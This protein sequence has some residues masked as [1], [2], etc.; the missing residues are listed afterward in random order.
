MGSIGLCAENF[1]PQVL[2]IFESI[3]KDNANTKY[4]CHDYL[5]LSYVLSGKGI[6]KVNDKT[7]KVKPGNLLPFNPNTYHRQ[8]AAKGE[9]FR[10]LHIGIKNFHF[11]G[12]PMDY[13]I[14]ANFFNVMDFSTESNEFLACCNEIIEEQKNRRPGYDLI[15]KALVMKLMAIV[16]RESGS[17]NEDKKETLCTFDS[18]EKSNIVRTIITFMNENYMK[19]ISLDKISKNMY[20]SPVY[21]S[22]IF[23]E[24]TGDSPINYLIKI[25]LEKASHLLKENRGISIK[26]ISK[27]VGYEDAYYFSKL[28][29]KY[30]G[31]SPSKFRS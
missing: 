26:E 21:I 24:E 10:E 29:K 22:K 28:F 6:Y 19:D 8:F 16:I 1:N 9:D 23:K 5:E 30:H 27:L 11:D 13:I 25:R 4:H 17:F 2:Y 3:S 14:S 18:S 31:Y 12:L 15:L 20:L 7:Y